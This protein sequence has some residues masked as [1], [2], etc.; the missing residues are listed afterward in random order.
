MANVINF[1]EEHEND[2][3]D[4]LLS[5][6]EFSR[7]LLKMKAELERCDREDQEKILSFLSRIEPQL[8]QA[9][10]AIRSEMDGVMRDLERRQQN[11][12]ACVAYLDSAKKSHPKRRK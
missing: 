12:Q 1:I 4:T 5:M 7:V 10:G 6:P 11:T 3:V 2:D 9:I 8:E